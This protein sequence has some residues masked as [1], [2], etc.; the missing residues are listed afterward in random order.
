MRNLYIASSEDPDQTARSSLIR[1]QSGMGT[2]CLIGFV[3]TYTE[4]LRNKDRFYVPG[5]VKISIILCSGSSI[6]N[7]SVMGALFK[8]YRVVQLF[9]L[10]RRTHLF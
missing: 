6:F 10:F 1:E 4:I 8:R 3:V 9:D 2:D 5:T 7:F